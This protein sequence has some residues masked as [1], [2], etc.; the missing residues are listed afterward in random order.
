MRRL[1]LLLL[2]LSGCSTMDLADYAG[3]QPAFA[4]ER[5]FLGETRAWGFFADR[6]GKVRREFTVDITGSLEDGLLTLDE[7]FMYADGERQQ[8][9]WKIRRQDD[10]TY[11]GR[12]GDIVGIAE[13]RTAGRAMNWIYDFE[14]PVGGSLWQVRFD[15]WMILQDERVMLNRTSISKFGIELGTVVIF[16]LRESPL[17]GEPAANA[18]QHL[19]H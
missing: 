7:R 11:E 9:I 17:E 2:L 13:G 16:F 6:F 10:G 4:P 14:L 8:R 15:D 12:A 19:A 3:T 5:Y 1:V 18:A